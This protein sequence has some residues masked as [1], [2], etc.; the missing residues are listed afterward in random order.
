MLIT[1]NVH[2]Q[3]VHSMSTN[4]VVC[5]PIQPETADQ[6]A[7]CTEAQL[8]STTRIALFTRSAIL[9]CIV[10]IIHY[11]GKLFSTGHCERCR[12]MCR[13]YLHAFKEI[14][15]PSMTDLSVYLESKSDDMSVVLSSHECSVHV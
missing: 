6:S 12:S 1:H 5:T 15:G 11:S 10:A 8:Y 9:G 4:G 7:D 14:I 2:R 13:P 3:Y